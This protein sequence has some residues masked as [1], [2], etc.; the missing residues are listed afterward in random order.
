MEIVNALAKQG[1]LVINDDN[2]ML[3]TV[4]L[5]DHHLLRVGQMMVVI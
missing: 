1:T 3:H 2:D 5:S 4:S